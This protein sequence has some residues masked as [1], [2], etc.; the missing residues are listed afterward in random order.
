MA[1]KEEVGR[2]FLAISL[3]STSAITSF[4]GLS[5]ISETP[6]TYLRMLVLYRPSMMMSRMMWSV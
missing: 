5:R 1:D 6:R 2:A 4:T 3:F